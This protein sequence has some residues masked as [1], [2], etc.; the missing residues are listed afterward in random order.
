LVALVLAGCAQSAMRQESMDAQPPVSQQPA[1]GEARKRAKVHTD[2][3]SAYYG[4][5]RMAIALE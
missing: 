2:L 1:V 3:G 4:S 5:G